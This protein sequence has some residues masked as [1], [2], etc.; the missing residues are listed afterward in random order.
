MTTASALRAPTGRPA[1]LLVAAGI[2][3]L[4]SVALRRFLNWAG[5]RFLF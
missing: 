4:L 1:R 2:Y 3:L 5:P